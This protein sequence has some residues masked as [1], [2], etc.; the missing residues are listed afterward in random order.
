MNDELWQV[1]SLRPLNGS[2]L[3]HTSWFTH[4]ASANEYAKWVEDGRGHVLSV[5]KYR[6]VNSTVY[7]NQRGNDGEL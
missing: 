1:V 4:E 6:L 5:R 7:K 3:R 2:E